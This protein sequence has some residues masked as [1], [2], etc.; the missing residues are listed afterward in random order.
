MFRAFLLTGTRIAGCAGSDIVGAERALVLRESAP[1]WDAPEPADK[2]DGY[3][4]FRPGHSTS[5]IEC[6]PQSRSACSLVKRSVLSAATDR[7]FR[8]LAYLSGCEAVRF[9]APAS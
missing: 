8:R 6:P 2:F 1:G 7:S 9:A 5:R 3:R 4:L